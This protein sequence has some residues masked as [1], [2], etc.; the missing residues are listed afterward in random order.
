[1]R[2]SRTSELFGKASLLLRLRMLKNM[3]ALEFRG[4]QRP[5]LAKEFRKINSLSVKSCLTDAK[6][7][8]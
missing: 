4:G 7:I 6:P 2:I 1:M 8:H 3:Q 5:M